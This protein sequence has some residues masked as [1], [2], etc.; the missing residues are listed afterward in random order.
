MNTRKFYSLVWV[1]IMMSL[2]TACGA[3]TP[4]QPQLNAA[5]FD[6]PRILTDFTAISN[7]GENFTLSEHQGELIL[8]YFGYRTCPDFCPTTAFELST[9]YKGLNEPSGALK[10]VFVT[11][12]PERDDLESLSRYVS[13]FHRDFIALRP[14]GADL[15]AL[16]NQFGVTATKRP[17]GDSPDAYLV[18][19]TASIFLINGDGKLYG[20]YLYGTPYEDIQSD[21][22]KLMKSL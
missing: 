11:V 12:D 10:I 17:M 16:M 14:E 13:A 3:K 20:Q 8:L 4:A 2:L 22:K 9:V 6:P 19:H 21:M 1:V 7:T 5:V 15:Q 18:D